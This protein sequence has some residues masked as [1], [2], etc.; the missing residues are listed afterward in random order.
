MQA[1]DWTSPGE[2]PLSAVSGL[3]DT[4][5]RSNVIHNVT[6]VNSC[7]PAYACG[8]LTIL[9]STAWSPVPS[10]CLFPSL[11]SSFFHLFFNQYL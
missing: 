10:S 2:V 9:A 11:I 7:G 8:L 4:K 5:L 6:Y 3:T 1:S